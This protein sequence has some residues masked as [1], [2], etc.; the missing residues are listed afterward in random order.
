MQF[1]KPAIA[2]ML[3]LGLTAA[4]T[5]A[6]DHGNGGASAQAKNKGNV[7]AASSEPDPVI[8]VSD[9]DSEMNAA[10]AEARATLPEWMALYRDRPSGYSNFALKFPLEGVEHIW[11]EVTSIEDGMVE[12]RLA[13]APHAEGWSYGDPVRFPMSAISDWAYWDASGVAHGYRTVEVL[14]TMMPEQE[15][16]AIRQRFGW[17]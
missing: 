12:G 11:V 1:L 4:P 2:G 10:M 17:E 5:S 7:Q 16:A 9:L 13:N 3:A 15:A 14:F 6:Q 8:A